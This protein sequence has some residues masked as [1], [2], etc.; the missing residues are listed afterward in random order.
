MKV[1]VISF[2]YGGC[3]RVFTDK[4]KALEFKRQYEVS[5]QEELLFQIKEVEE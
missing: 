1:Y 2:T 5:T 4:S 3:V